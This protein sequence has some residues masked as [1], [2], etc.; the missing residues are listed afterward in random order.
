MT[1]QSGSLSKEEL[2]A[3]I[4]CARELGVDV[5]SLQSKNP[6]AMDTPRSMSIQG[7]MIKRFP[8]IAQGLIERAEE[9]LSLGAQA[10]LEGVE[11]VQM[12][13]ALAREVATKRPQQWAD[14]EAA[15]RA[16][17]AARF[18]ESMQ[19]RAAAHAEMQGQIA[20]QMADARM[21]SIQVAAHSLKRY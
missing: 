18:E 3:L 2:S 14:M 6:W 16:E 4:V 12:T 5:T 15:R 10:F 20:A 13:D 1:K 11:G 9:P 7:L 21:E 8:R 17:V 19:A